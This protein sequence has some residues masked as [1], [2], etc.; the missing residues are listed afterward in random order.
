MSVPTILLFAFIALLAFKGL[1]GDSYRHAAPY[2]PY[3]APAPASNGLG[4]IAGL[5]IAVASLWLLL[6]IP[7]PKDEPA[8]L[9]P[10]ESRESPAPQTTDIRR[11]QPP[12]ERYFRETTKAGAIHEADQNG[13]ETLVS[14]HDVGEPI[15]NQP[16][17]GSGRLAVA[18][19]CYGSREEAE[20]LA[21]HFQRRGIQIFETSSGEYLACIP[22]TTLYQ[23]YHEVEDWDAHEEDW[24]DMGLY[25]QVVRLGNSAGLRQY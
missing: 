24:V 21:R 17:R 12:P 23:G 25:P 2:P 19:R 15:R 10:V 11:N 9:A 16:P 18:L 3:P 5:L 1:L 7:S 8:P 14:D 4:I 13:T 6:Q 20:R 22:V